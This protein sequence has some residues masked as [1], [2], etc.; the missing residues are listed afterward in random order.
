MA[1]LWRQFL[2]PNL[3]KNQ[4]KFW[5]VFID[6]ERNHTT[7]LLTC[8]KSGFQ[9]IKWNFYVSK[10]DSSSEY[11]GA[12]NDENKLTLQLENVQLM[13]SLGL[14]CSFRLG[15]YSFSRLGLSSKLFLIIFGRGRGPFFSKIFGLPSGFPGWAGKVVVASKLGFELP[16][17]FL[18]SPVWVFMKKF[19]IFIFILLVILFLTP[20]FLFEVPVL[21]CFKKKN[22]WSYF[23]NLDFWYFWCCCLSLWL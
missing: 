4:Q 10:L 20:F 16:L 19:V 1:A 7:I 21:E 2:V 11:Y 5:K 13:G 17:S 15:S 23:G 14:F 3:T 9:D 12:S 18:C 6:E 22:S 8:F